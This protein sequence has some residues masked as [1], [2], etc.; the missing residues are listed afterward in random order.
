MR[1]F[2]IAGLQ[3]E[4]ADGGNLT[5]MAEQ[6]HAAKRRFPW[7]DMVVL[8]ELACHGVNTVHAE[9]MPGASEAAFCRLAREVGVWLVAG[10]LFERDGARIF[11]T[12]PVINP[13]GE[14]VARY[15]KMYPF[16]PYEAGVSGGDGFCVFDVPHVGRIGL[17]ICYD[18]WFPEIARTLAW[19]GAEAIITPSLTNTV[20]RDVE[21]A[22]ARSAAA[23]NQCYVI[24]VNG[25]GQL[26]LG[27]SI[28]CGPGGEILYQAGSGQE[29]FV[30]EL[31]FDTVARVR[32][33]GWNGLG[34]VL[35]SFRDH[36]I[37]FPPYQPDARS[38]ALD[39]LG[40]L[41]KPEKERS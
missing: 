30:L 6:V 5:A 32:E 33:R 23:S 27:R 21:L 7:L 3:L 20:D 2:S 36:P 40:P 9:P 16:Y 41:V 26:G 4:L 11:N 18:I 31:D 37:V 22:L 8:S 1:T 10:S 39:G 38:T 28:A 15:R 19:M 29:A 35:K 25:A 34:Q 14:V 17:S 12:A 24:N 13:L